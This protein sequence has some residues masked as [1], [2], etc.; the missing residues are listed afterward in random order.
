MTGRPPSQ[1]EVC[2][3][4]TLNRTRGLPA[5]AS[6][7]SQWRLLSEGGAL[8]AAPRKA[9][10]Q[11]SPEPD[12]NT[13]VRGAGRDRYQPARWPTRHRRQYICITSCRPLRQTS[14]MSPR[15]RMRPSPAE[16]KGG[17]SSIASQPSGSSRPSQASTAE[18]AASS[19]SVGSA[20]MQQ[21][22]PQIA[23]DA[24]SIISNSTISQVS[25]WAHLF[26]VHPS[27]IYPPLSCA[28]C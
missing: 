26:C 1:Q 24:A 27:C 9:T 16:K 8:D 12:V 22:Q 6:C 19:P 4:T 28:G 21:P 11:S 3:W 14:T 15:K 5:T 2:A 23:S 10:E 20:T 17:P 25:I 18:E 7:S 13:S